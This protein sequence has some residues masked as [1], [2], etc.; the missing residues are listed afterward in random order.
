MVDSEEWIRDQDWE[1][2]DGAWARME[3]LAERP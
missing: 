2:R 1:L 3:S